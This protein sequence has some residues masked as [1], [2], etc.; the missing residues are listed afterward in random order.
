MRD[1]R[2]LTP[3][4]VAAIEET[5]RR[6]RTETADWPVVHIGQPAWTAHWEPIDSTIVVPFEETPEERAKVLGST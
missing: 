2:A 1:P 3:E 4:E 5:E 6:V